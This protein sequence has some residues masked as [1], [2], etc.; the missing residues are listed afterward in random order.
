MNKLQCIINN[1]KQALKI[2]LR[3]DVASCRCLCIVV[4][5]NAPIFQKDWKPPGDGPGRDDGAPPPDG[6]AGGSADN[7]LRQAAQPHGWCKKCMLCIFTLL[8]TNNML[9]CMY[10]LKYSFMIIVLNKA[11]MLYATAYQTVLSGE[12]EVFLRKNR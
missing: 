12:L 10:N 7:P 3:H 9:L 6:S 11:D 5:M 4:V 8:P 1:I 2:D